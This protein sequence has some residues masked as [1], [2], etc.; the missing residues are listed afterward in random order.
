MMHESAAYGIY[1][2]GVAL[3][4]VLQT[5]GD[6][7][8]EKENICMMLSP[9][10]PI[11]TI[12]RDFSAQP[13]ERESN[14]VTAGLIGWLSEFG[15]VVIPTFGFFIRS[16]EFFHALL[17][18]KDSTAGCGSSGG[19]LSSLGF[20]SE[21]AQRF[22]NQVR[23]DG[24]LLYVSCPETAQRHWAL[25]LL[26]ATGADEAGLLDNVHTENAYAMEAYA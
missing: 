21:E 12:V 15:A 26:R 11:A 16:R 13:F 7:G 20:S 22:E 9:K 4:E 2:D 18:E 19:T 17:M 6:G 23:L 1:P 10:H 8:F 25:E 5:L 24:V 14:V 3:K